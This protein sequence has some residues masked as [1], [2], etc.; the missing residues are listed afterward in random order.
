MPAHEAPL[1]ALTFE[2]L[3]EIAVGETA[4]VELCRV[5]KGPL[6]DCL[7]A[8]KRLHPHIADDPQFSDMFR[9]E[10]WMAQALQHKHV[11]RVVGWGEDEFGRY[12]ASEF[13]RGVSLQRLMK[14][15]V[16]TGEHFSERMVVYLAA[17][18]CGGLAEAHA[19]RGQDGQL[20]ELVHRDLTPGNILLG[21]DG[22]V[23]IID[24]GLAKAKQRLTRTMTGVLKGKPLY[25][26]PEQLLDQHVDA[27]SDIFSLG[28]VLFETFS[29]QLPWSGTNQIELM[30]AMTETEPA[31][32][33]ALRPKMD[34]ALGRLVA[35]CLA[36]NPE[37]RY[38]SAVAL[39]EE[40]MHWLRA[41]GYQEG[42]QRNLSR[43]IRRNAM[44]Q[45]RWFEKAIEGAY[46][47]QTRQEREA[48]LSEQ[49][50]GTGFERAPISV[51]APV[52]LRPPEPRESQPQ[53]VADDEEETEWRNEPPTLIQSGVDVR[54]SGQ[55]PTARAT[56]TSSAPTE[57][58]R[59]KEEKKE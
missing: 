22:A 14:T 3:A 58:Q 2:L 28:V 17:S 48:R 31:D 41:H 43:F 25:M 45:M 20:L 10:I 56:M 52:S 47:E 24:F 38:Q 18:V 8:V 44:R 59:R 9:D 7:V 33:M 5:T 51:G 19:L 32:L 53:A 12:L 37:D 34:R 49:Y 1:S 21:F 39:R 4:T 29:G 57:K 30:R 27:R 26:A 35:K 23:G 36:R 46:A 16:A 55:V 50:D 54:R 13:V 42:N 11:V 15:I 6:E 40:L